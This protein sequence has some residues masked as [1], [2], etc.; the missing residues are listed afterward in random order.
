MEHKPKTIIYKGR[1]YHLNRG[2][3]KTTVAL[4]Q[5]VWED[6]FGQIP[7]NHH[8]HHKNGDSTDNR[9][10]NL[11]CL[12]KSKHHSLHFRASRQI[13]KMH[14]KEARL[15][16][17]EWY[18]S[19]KGRLVLGN[20]SKRGWETRKSVERNCIICGD[21]FQTK[22]MNGTKYC[23]SICRSRCQALRESVEKNCLICGNYFLTRNYS[24]A[25][26]TCSRVCK[27]RLISKTK[28]EKSNDNIPFS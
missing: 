6:H 9:I 26:K 14:S 3:F 18:R 16:A 12:H 5:V 27:G 19:P 21:A 24:Q 10:E 8:I 28:K 23:S 15:K 22:N 25:S 2:Y 20:I 13:K 1:K 11:E 7:E 17:L 4:H